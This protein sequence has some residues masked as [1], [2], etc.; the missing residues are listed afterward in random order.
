V[1]SI[2]S[3]TP[4]AACLVAGLALY[5]TR[6]LLDQ[7]V[8]ADGVVRFAMLPPWQALVGFI[9]LAALVLVGIDHLNAPRGTSTAK[10]PRLRD[11][12]PPIFALGV[13]LLPFTPVLPDRWPALQT[14]AGPLGAIVWL[15]VMA[16]QV[17][18]LWQ[19]RLITARPIERWRLTTVTI[20]IAVASIAASS[21]AA[22]RLTSTPLFPSG[23][24]PHYLVLSQSIWRDGDLKI[25]N[26][27]QRGD[28]LEYYESELEPHYLTRGSDQEIY[29]IHPVGISVLMAPVYGAAGY[30]GVVAALI[31][32]AAVAMA[33]AWRWTV[34][35]LNAPGAAT[36]AWA[37][38][39]LTAPFLL[40]T[41][42]VYPEIAA[43]L[44]VIFAFV[45]TLPREQQRPGLGRWIAAGIAIAVAPW[46]STKYAPMSAALLLVVLARLASKREPA[47][48][49]RN[50]KAW[51]VV[52]I[53]AISLAAWFA[54]STRIGEIHCRWRRMDR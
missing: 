53:Y 25:E 1:S 41:F 21:L 16:L 50:S 44:A 32:M 9:C 38:I 48:L 15:A 43:G 11:L 35:T 23:D 51:V 20:A 3:L 7:T 8:T 37:S 54:F 47:S 6:G 13:L 26:N 24:E 45:W 49:L 12:V 39:A 22:A 27:H 4:L 17:W 36:F 33:I 29:S 42:T 40:N 30:R 18:V 14:L 28:Y 10:R 52:G 2:A 19:S 46:L 34:A 5:V 31:L